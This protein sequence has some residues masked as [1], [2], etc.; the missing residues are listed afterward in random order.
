[1]YN[2]VGY[3]S[4]YRGIGVLGESGLVF[5]FVIKIHTYTQ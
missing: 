2:L 1:M 5:F 4:G 3:D